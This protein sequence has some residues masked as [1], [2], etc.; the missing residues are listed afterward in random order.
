MKEE[1]RLSIHDN[2]KG[3]EVNA[4]RPDNNGIRIMRYRAE[5]VGGNL[6]VESIPGDGSNVVLTIP[7]TNCR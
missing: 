3:F 1:F 4:D 6:E 7:A 2:G 5:S